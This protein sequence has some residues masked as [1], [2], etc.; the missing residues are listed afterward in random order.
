MDSLRIRLAKEAFKFSSTHFTILGVSTAE[1]LHGHNYQVAVECELSAVGVL[2]MGFEFNSLKPNIRKLTE[3]W[4]E[5]VLIPKKCAD[6]AITEELVRGE[7]HWSIDFSGKNLN[8]SYRF[9]K[10]DVVFL[11]TT[12]VTSEELARLF[13]IELAKS[14]RSTSTGEADLAGRVKSLTV[15]IEETRGQSASFTMSSPLS[16]T[17]TQ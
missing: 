6:I 16:R 7:A 13:A 17:D 10:A 3:R 11:E 9:P 4:D 8:R 14:W 2:G 5:R 15:T 1:R 12:N